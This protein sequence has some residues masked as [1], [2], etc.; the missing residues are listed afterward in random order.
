MA[1]PGCE[2]SNQFFKELKGL[3]KIMDGNDKS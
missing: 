2:I 3:K 1:A